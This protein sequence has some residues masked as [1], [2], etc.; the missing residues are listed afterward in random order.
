MHTSEEQAS[1]LEK[2][3]DDSRHEH[4]YTILPLMYTPEELEVLYA[5]YLVEKDL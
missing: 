1:A 5:K 3:M 4:T 2:F